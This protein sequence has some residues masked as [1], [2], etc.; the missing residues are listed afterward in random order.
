[1]SWIESHD[2][3][4]DHWKTEKL[5]DL[6]CPHFDKTMHREEVRAL[7]VGQLQSLWHFVLRNA[8]RDANLEPWGDAGIERA[9][10]WMRSA[11]ALTSALREVGYLDGYYAHG[12]L[13]RAGRL[14]YDRSRKEN[15]RKSAVKRRTNGGQ[16]KATLPYP[17]LPNRTQP[18]DLAAYT[19]QAQTPGMAEGKTKDPFHDFMDRFLSQ[20]L[21][22]P[23]GSKS[24]E[25]LRAVGAAYRRFGR[26]G[27]DVLALALG[28]PDK[29][30]SGTL[31]VGTWLESSG[32]SWTLD[33]VAK[34][35][36]DWSQNPEGFG[37]D[38][39]NKR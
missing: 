38:G 30:F 23:V 10:R 11:G 16:S 18:T 19:P 24:P 28:D 31:A 7:I 3:I 5:I 1:M 37:K 12:W 8:W 29:A 4:W 17:T 14:V 2:D 22:L 26:A 25:H 27:R 34:W 13:E 36:Q 32:L 20:C 15:S 6:L 33:T 39:K 21:K 9:A 35:F